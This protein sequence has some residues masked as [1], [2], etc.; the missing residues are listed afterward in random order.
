MSPS[1]T[2]STHVLDLVAGG[3]AQGVP[4][5]LDHLDGTTWVRLA[6]GQTDADGRLPG[7]LPA[8]APQQ[9]T[10]RLCFDTGSWFARTQ[11]V[12]FYP[13]VPIV[14]RIDAPGAHYHVPLLLGP[15]GYSTYRGS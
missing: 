6:Q 14:F 4:V 5:R 10:F 2:L 15:F 7:L 8:E 13:E 11:T 9:G 1:T 3:P 12:A